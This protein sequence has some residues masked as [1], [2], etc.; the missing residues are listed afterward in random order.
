MVRFS[1]EKAVI[2][3]TINKHGKL[4]ENRRKIITFVEF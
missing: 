2:K 3:K 1:C 4:L